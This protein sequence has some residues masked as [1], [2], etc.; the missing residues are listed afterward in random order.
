MK[1]NRNSFHEKPDFS[2]KKINHPTLET[3]FRTQGGCCLS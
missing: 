1:K 2:E 3:S